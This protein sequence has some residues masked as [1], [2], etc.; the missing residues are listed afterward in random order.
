MEE[1]VSNVILGIAGKSDRFVLKYGWFKFRL[2]IKPLTAEMMIRMSGEISKIKTIDKDQDVFAALMAG[3][4]DLKHI[5][6]VIAISTG[7]RFIRLISRAVL[8]LPLSDIQTLFD[9][10]RKQSDPAPFFFIIAKT[11]RLNLL[12]TAK[13]EEVS[14]FGDGS[15]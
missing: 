11:G 14:Q 1:Q 13:Q 15:P 10:V 3:V 7:T 9:I 4:P 8:K 5:S 12:K 2:K 6:K